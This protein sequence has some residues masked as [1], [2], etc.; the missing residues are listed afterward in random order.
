[1]WNATIYISRNTLL[2]PLSRCRS[3]SDYM[4]IIAIGNPWISAKRDLKQ[5]VRIQAMKAARISGC[6]YNLIWINKYMSIEC[7]ARIYKTSVRPVLTCIANE[8]RNSLHPTTSPNNRDE[9]YKGNTR[10]DA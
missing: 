4:K 1:M 2:P 9:N 5:E 6:L 7:K 8:S 3:I 10:K